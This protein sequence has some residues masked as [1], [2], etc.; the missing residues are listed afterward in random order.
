MLNP[1]IQAFFAAFCVKRFCKSHVC[2]CT[3]FLVP[4]VLLLHTVESVEDWGKIGQFL[5]PLFQDRDTWRCRRFYTPHMGCLQHH[6]SAPFHT[7]KFVLS[8]PEG[9]DTPLPTPTQNPVPLCS[10][11]SASPF[12]LKFWHEPFQSM[13]YAMMYG[14]KGSTFLPPPRTP[15]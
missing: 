6:A 4:F 5:L 9:G 1:K 11:K 2:G 15:T 7:N 3:Q 12:S 13:L 8:P 14:A 10:L